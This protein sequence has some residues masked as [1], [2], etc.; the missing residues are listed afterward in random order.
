MKK[1]CCIFYHWE[2]RLWNHQSTY[3]KKIQ[4]IQSKVHPASEWVAQAIFP[5][6]ILMQAKDEDHDERFLV[7]GPHW[8]EVGDES[9]HP[10][11]FLKH[12]FLD[13]VSAEGKNHLWNEL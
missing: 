13:L 2:C 6:K 11:R 3:P 5:T 4:K 8:K 1:L 12:I 10:V 7:Q 9:P